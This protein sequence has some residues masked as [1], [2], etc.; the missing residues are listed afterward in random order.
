MRYLS[1]PFPKLLSLVFIFVLAVS[2]ISAQDHFLVELESRSPDVKSLVGS[3]EG[4]PLI[5]IMAKDLNGVEHNLMAMKGKTV[6][7]WFWN[8]DCPKCFGQIDAFNQLTQNHSDKLQVISF[9]DNSK[10]EMNEFIK[11]T[12]V[13]FPV[14]PHSKT[15]ADGPYGG[16]LGYPRIFIIDEFGITKWVIPEIEMRG[17]FQTYPFLE[18]LLRSIQKK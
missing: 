7:L 4:Q 15:L 2:T 16:D 10:E 8:L 1:I 9:S 17:D 11:T 18:T 3:Y 6:M 12:P 14:I 13:D 5:P